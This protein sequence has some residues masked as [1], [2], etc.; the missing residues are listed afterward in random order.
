MCYRGK[1]GGGVVAFYLKF[2]FQFFGF[3]LF[4]YD[5]LCQKSGATLS[6]FEIWYV[7]LKKKLLRE[8]EGGRGNFNRVFAYMYVYYALICLTR[9][10]CKMIHNIRPIDNYLRCKCNICPLRRFFVLSNCAKVTYDFSWLYLHE[11]RLS[12]YQSSNYLVRF[13][14]YKRSMFII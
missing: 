5:F 11:S 13:V 12:H 10:I 9:F 14:W 3:F 2:I 4:Q 1:G 8:K 6:K 7:N